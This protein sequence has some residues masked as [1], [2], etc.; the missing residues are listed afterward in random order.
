MKNYQGGKK[1][2]LISSDQVNLFLL[3]ILFLLDPDPRSEHWSGPK[4]TGL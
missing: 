1:A 2:F 3:G 4:K